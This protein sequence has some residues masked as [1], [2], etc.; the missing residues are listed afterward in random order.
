[1]RGILCLEPIV[2]KPVRRFERRSVQW[3]RGDVHR[4]DN[5]TECDGDDHNTDPHSG[6]R[7]RS[8]H[9]NDTRPVSSDFNVTLQDEEQ[10][11]WA[12]PNGGLSNRNLH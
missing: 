6:G 1:M 12:A 11:I 5:G 4:D 7:G 10:L 3:A 2:L 8:G 9:G